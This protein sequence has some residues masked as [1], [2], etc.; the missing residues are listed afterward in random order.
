[1]STTDWIFAA[2]LTAC[3]IGFAVSWRMER[4]ASRR[5]RM[6]AKALID[7][8]RRRHPGEEL[9]CRFLREIDAALGVPLTEKGS[10]EQARS[11]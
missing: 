8:V 6:A 7:D 4:R 11:D 2:L 5:V 9:R 1:M 10:D 3:T